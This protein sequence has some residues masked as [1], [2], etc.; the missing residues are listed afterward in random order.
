MPPRPLPARRKHSI[1]PKPFAGLL[2]KPLCNACEHAANRR[3]TPLSSSPPAL[4]FTQ[5]RQRTID[6]QHHFCPEQD[7]S[8]SGWHGRGNIRANG[9]PGGKPWW[10]FQYVAC[11]EYFALEERDV[12]DSGFSLE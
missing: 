12:E 1:D 7:C 5:G 9:H 4:V 11:N 6:T 10:Q 3:P 2:H 8:Y